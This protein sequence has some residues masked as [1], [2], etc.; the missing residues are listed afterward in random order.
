MHLSEPLTPSLPLGPSMKGP[1]ATLIQSSHFIDGKAE[2][3]P[4]SDALVID[5]IQI[6]FQ[7]AP[8]PYFF[9]VFLYFLSQNDF[10]STFLIKEAG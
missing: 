5:K 1:E 10:K 2:T 8:G 9:F 4:P 6:H 3:E 7:M